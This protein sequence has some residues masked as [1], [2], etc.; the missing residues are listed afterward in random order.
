MKLISAV[1]LSLTI[2]TAPTT[3][4]DEY[5]NICIED[6]R[7]RLDNF[8]IQLQNDETKICYIIVYA[9]RSSCVDEAKYR[10]N[11]AKA[12]V[13]KRGVPSNRV[14]VK[15]GG[16]MSEIQTKLLLLSTEMA[17]PD[18]PQTLEK[19]NVSIHKCVDKVFARVLCPNRK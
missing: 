6:E 4:F 11:R 9:G 18:P 14:T 5:G 7:A 19:K 10:G 1:L 15:D 16:F 2:F 13:V 8:A 3:P 17:L 12:W